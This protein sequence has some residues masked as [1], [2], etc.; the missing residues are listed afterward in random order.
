MIGL[1]TSC[2]RPDLLL[3]TLNSFYERQQSDVNLTI[4]EDANGIP[5]IN[6]F[7]LLSAFP[8]TM[9][10]V[11]GGL[12]QHKSIEKFLEENNAKYYFH[13]EDDFFFQNNYDWIEQSVR[14]MEQDTDI[15]KV[16]ACKTTPHPCS[17]NHLLKDSGD[18]PTHY[19]YLQPW[20]SNDG[21]LWHGFSWNPGITRLDLLKQFIPFPKWEQELAQ[22]IYEA[23]LHTVELYDKVYSHIGENR[24]TH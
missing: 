19:G 14:I 17:H 21:I 5:E 23:G 11:T 9:L 1:V 4:H 15:I 3:Q 8:K 6:A 12:G 20:T 7:A 24:S 16:L 2:N 10:K 22:N 18:P 13:C